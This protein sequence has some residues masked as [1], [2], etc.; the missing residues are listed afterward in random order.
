MINYIIDENG[1]KTHVVVPID[2]WNELSIDMDINQKETTKLLNETIGTKG[3]GIPVLYHA[4]SLLS[5]IESPTFSSALKEILWYINNASASEIGFMYL[6]RTPEFIEFIN[7]N[8]FDNNS[9]QQLTKD[10][11]IT[12]LQGEPLSTEKLEIFYSIIIN[13]ATPDQM[14][15]HLKTICIIGIKNNKKRIR[16]DADMKRLFIFDV[17]ENF[18][19]VMPELIKDMDSFKRSLALA[20][21]P[22]NTEDSAMA[23]FNKAHREAKDRIYSSGWIEYLGIN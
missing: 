18:T 8:S 15:K 13:S 2:K 23:Q 17:V 6:L 11:Y 10:F 21:Y 5:L 7:K 1:N 3:N 4:I 12:D 20:L 14:L 19:T 16:R 9:I 22:E